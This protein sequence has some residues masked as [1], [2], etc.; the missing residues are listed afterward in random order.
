[1][2]RVT[3]RRDPSAGAASD[4]DASAR[5]SAPLSASAQRVQDAIRALGFANTVF[6]LD[7][8]VRTAADAA[9][10]VGCDVARICKSVIFQAQQSG[11]PVLVVTSGAN[12]VN[13]ARI[14][15]LL[16]EP[17]GRAA[18]DFVRA[19]TGYAIGGIPP[20]GHVQSPVTFID[21]HLL[22]LDELWA[23]AGHPNALFRLTPDELVRMTGGQV[24]AVT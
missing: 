18:P 7:V 23:A 22:E 19:S 4:R 11:R 9:N 1:V 20:I 3:E 8:P 10:A 14:G 16:G 24:A 12:R 13:E 21:S 6:E 17:I 5:R 2:T 15:A